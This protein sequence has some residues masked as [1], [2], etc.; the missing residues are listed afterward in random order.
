MNLQQL[1][2][3]Y[4]AFRQALGERFKS[5]A[6]VLRAFGRTIGTDA[7]VAEIR[8]EQVNAFLAGTGPITRT[9]R[10]KYD[11]LSGFYRYAVSRGYATSCPLPTV[12]PK[13]PS[14]LVPYIYSHEELHR[15]LQATDSYQQLR[16][17]MEPVTVRTLVL[18]L[19]GTGLR[20]RETVDLNRADVDLDGSLLTVRQTKFFKTRLVPFSPSLAHALSQYAARRQGPAI[21][22]GDQAAFFTTRTGDRVS[23]ETLRGTFRRVCEHAGIRRHDGGRYQPRLHDLRHTFAVHRLT[24]WYRQGADVQKLLPQLSVYLGHAHLAATQVY[25]SMTPELLREAC[26]RFE[27]YAGE[28]GCHD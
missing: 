13:R 6:A 9:W 20:C 5:N 21:I 7:D 23:Q 14:S 1:I 11:A 25:L 2:E 27:R 12:I 28:E 10:V 26:T 18:L 8:G 19:Y 24:S 4:V 3:Q 16:S 17:C 15:L 22:S